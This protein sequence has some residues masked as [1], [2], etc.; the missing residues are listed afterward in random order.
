MPQTENPLLETVGLPPF[1]RITA[2]HVV[3]AVREVLSECEERMEAIEAEIEPRWERVISPLEAIGRRLEHSWGPVTHLFGVKNSDELRSA[4]EEVLPEVVSFG[5]RV[6]QSEPLYRALKGI[7][8]GAAWEQLDEAQQRIVERKLLS[9]ELS[10]IGL[11]GAARERFNEIAKELSKLGSDFSNHVLDATKAYSLIISDAGDADGLPLS[12]RRLTSDSYNERREEGSRESTPDDGPWRISLDQPILV[13]FLKHCRNRALREEAYRA[14]VTRA[15]AGELDNAPLC[16]RILELRREQARLLGYETYAEMSLAEKMAPSV[17]DVLS[18]LERLRSASWEPANGDLQEIH[19][20]AIASGVSE[21]PAH[22]DIAFWAERL[23]ERKFEFSDEELRPYFPH[24]RVLNGLFSLAERLFGIQVVGAD[25]EAPRWHG[26]V[27]FFK[28]LDESGEQIAAF[29]YDPYSRPENKRGGAW[30]DDCLSRCRVNGDVQLPVAHLV[31]NGTPPAGGKP[32]L[33]T[34][35][36]VE[37]LFHE[38]GHGLQHML[39]RV[40]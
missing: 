7:R 29:Y 32:A 23:R 28:V 21:P 40:A 6:R 3:P 22:W 24:E 4:Y 33:M 34:F 30:M 39:T 5:L 14:H 9:A 37:T 2:E 16:Q 27:R 31:C 35:R 8:E 1:D 17:E 10:G 15:S 26:D 36:E 20:L 25:E 13:P 19:E 12:L 11:S 18:M 38:F